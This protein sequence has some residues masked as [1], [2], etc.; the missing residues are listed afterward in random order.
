M[1]QPHRAA[2]CYL[3]FKLDDISSYVS[4]WKLNGKLL[5][6]T[7]YSPLFSFVR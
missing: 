1:T 2:E 3:R 4:L 5:P 7:E 6:S